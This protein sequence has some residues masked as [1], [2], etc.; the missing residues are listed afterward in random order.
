MLLLLNLSK[1]HSFLG[2]SQRLSHAVIRFVLPF[3]WMLL[4]VRIFLSM[5][6]IMRSSFMG[7]ILVDS[8]NSRVTLSGAVESMTGL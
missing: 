6:R 7:L 4:S 2:C 5:L 3:L 1:Q 8:R